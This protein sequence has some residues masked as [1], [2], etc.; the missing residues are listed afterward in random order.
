[1]CRQQAFDATK[2]IPLKG[3]GD[4]QSEKNIYISGSTERKKH[5]QKTIFFART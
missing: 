2:I 4:A 1:M 5:V 3:D